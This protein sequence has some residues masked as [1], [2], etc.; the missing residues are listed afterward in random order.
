MQATPYQ[1]P[2]GC[3]WPS[4]ILGGLC[5]TV[6]GLSLLAVPRMWQRSQEEWKETVGVIIEPYVETGERYNR[7][8]FQRVGRTLHKTTHENPTYHVRLKYRYNIAEKEYDGEAPALR[9]P[10]DDEDP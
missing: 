7:E 1:P 6:G 8:S 9:Q 3:M 5:L 2:R 4:L 10:D